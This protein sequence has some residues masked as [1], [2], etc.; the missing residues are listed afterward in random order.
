MIRGALVLYLVLMF[1]ASGSFA[2]NPDCA[3]ELIRMKDAYK[4]YSAYIMEGNMQAYYAP[5]YNTAID[6]QRYVFIKSGKGYNYSIGP[7]EIMVSE[8]YQVRID[9]EEKS[10]SYSKI[11]N[12]QSAID[13]AEQQFNM[14]IQNVASSTTAKYSFKC[15]SIDKNQRSLKFETTGKLF[16]QKAQF[17]YDKTSFEVSRMI[18]DDVDPGSGK[19]FRLDCRFNTTPL[20]ESGAGKL[21]T[22]RDVFHMKNGK[23]EVNKA[24]QS[25]RVLNN[26]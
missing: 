17:I 11:D 8:K 2:Q 25:Y 22:W 26:S 9:H 20:K 10:I 19:E 15:G 16:H 4:K 14:L 21:K 23:L 24:F 18:V 12:L 7:M 1:Y 13:V 3:L 6:K 5:D